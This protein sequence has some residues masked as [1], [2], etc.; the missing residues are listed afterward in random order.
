[1]EPAV[2]RALRWALRRIGRYPGDSVTMILTLAVGVG[3]VTAVVSVY[4]AVVARALPYR[5][6][7]ELVRV[8][9]NNRPKGNTQSRVSY[10]NLL[11]WRART[12]C[13]VGLAGFNNPLPTLRDRGEPIQ[14]AGGRVTANFFSVL[15]IEPVVGRGFLPEDEAPES[16]RVVVLSEGLWRRRYGGDPELLGQTITLDGTPR[17]VVG[18]V[19]EALDLPRGAELWI[20]QEVTPELR[21]ARG[22]QWFEVVGR[23][24]PGASLAAAREELGRV[25]SLL[26]REYPEANEGQGVT[27]TPLKEEALGRVQ[28]T[29][30]SL[31]A[32][33]VLV[34]LIGCANVGNLVLAKTIGRRREVGICS[35]LGASRARLLRQQ[36]LEYL[37]IGLGGG[38]LGIVLAR[39]GLDLLISLHPSALPGLDR[40]R[41]NL[42]V[43][44]FGLA[45]SSLTG[46]AFGA[47]ATW[48]TAR[49][50]PAALLHEAT[51]GGSVGRRG[52]AAQKGLVLVA[53]SLAFVLSATAA[54][55]LQSARKLQAV[56]LGFTTDHLLTLKVVLPLDAYP[57][58]ASRAGFFRTAV[59]RLGRLPGVVGA[60]AAF[61]APFGEVL[62]IFPFRLEHR[63]PV[64]GT[65]AA[66][67]VATP[68]YFRALRVPLR[69]GRGFTDRD[70]EDSQRVAVINETMARQLPPDLDPIG[71]RI[72]Y[73]DP[74]FGNNPPERFVEWVE[75]V[76]L[77]SDMRSQGPDAAAVPEI[78]L[79]AAQVHV[80]NMSLVLKTEGD[81]SAV[82]PAAKAAIHGIDPDL[83]ILRIATLDE[84]YRA[85]VAER[86][87]NLLLT[88]FLAGIGV[89][90]AAGGLYGL[91]SYL[92]RESTA[93]MAVRSALGASRG[94][95]L[96][97]I[98]RMG[99]GLI[100]GGLVLGVVLYLLVAWA[101][102]A[103][104]GP[105]LFDVNLFD[106]VLGLTIALLLTVVGTTAVFIP[107]WRATRLDPAAALDPDRS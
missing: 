79:P 58:G 44:A 52:A 34:L 96:G 29:V 13:L 33:A 69:R 63:E 91:V 75:V 92:V 17:T 28:T 50:E 76:G 20:P 81:P 49:L 101:L 100:A 86:H 103:A 36:L 21:A 43:L 104:A 105:L 54:L 18:V 85:S 46:I 51:R 15:G 23:L 72:A 87:F 42:P 8:W 89:C 10:P 80:R 27:V 88:A 66:M 57:D 64:Q 9:Q 82:I 70:R 106:P 74:A 65:L 39:W 37:L 26:E 11:D 59:D 2:K 31:A 98:L 94:A 90:L 95:L 99:L 45:V 83:P 61:N 60:E 71:R 6:P 14:V 48:R 41:W 35:A 68:G 25:A 38:L 84:L 4:D 53:V 73:W 16:P 3:A 7:D 55:L 102:G 97:L 77:V 47:L 24:A 1:M 12:S 32:G 78:Y 62:P 22:S 67:E 19:P 5:S 93:A 56:D 40:V 30:L 107:A